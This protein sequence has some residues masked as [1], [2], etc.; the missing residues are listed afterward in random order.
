MSSSAAGRLVVVLPDPTK[1]KGLD[2]VSEQGNGQAA[3]VCTLR[4]AFENRWATDAHIL[5]ATVEP[6]DGSEPQFRWHKAALPSI[7][8][9]GYDL[10]L[11]RI[12]LEW[13]TP[14]HVEWTRDLW[15][16]YNEMI[17]TA[18]AGPLK[19][20]L[21]G[22]TAYY[23]TRRGVRWVFELSRDLPADEGESYIRGLAAFFTLHGIAVD[24]TP[25][26]LTW[27]QPFR[28]PHVVRD[29]KDKDG[30]V[31]SRSN[32]QDD[33]FFF[34]EHAYDRFLDPSLITPVAKVEAPAAVAVKED[35]PE[36]DAAVALVWGPSALTTLGVK[37]ERLLRG[38]DYYDFVFKF[39]APFGIEREKRHD[40]LMKWVASATTLLAREEGMTP[41][42]IY[43]IFIQIAKQF[44]AD[45]QKNGSRPFPLVELWRE[46]AWAWGREQGQIQ[47]EKAKVAAEEAAKVVEQQKTEARKVELSE[48]ITSG[49]RSWHPR[50]PASAVDAWMW[51]QKRFLVQTENRYYVMRPDGLY[52]ERDVSGTGIL[53]QVEHLNMGAVIQTRTETKQGTRPATL[54]E[55]TQRHVVV[56]AEDVIFKPEIEGGYLV[57]P[58][59]PNPM[60]V[61][62]SF[63]RRRDIKP[64]WNDN[65][66]RW[67]RSWA[68]VETRLGS[69]EYAWSQAHYDLFNRIIGCWLA[70]ERGAV[71]ALSLVA[72]NDAGK[73]LFGQ[74]FVE[75]FEK[76]G[77][78]TARDLSEG[79]NGSLGKYCLL[80]GNEG[81]QL[82]WGLHHPSDTFRMLVTG[83]TI[84]VNRKHRDIVMVSN[85]MRVL[86]T[87]NNL[88]LLMQLC[89]NRDLDPEDRRAIGVRLN[90]FAPGDAPCKVLR[91][92][93]GP[94]GTAGWIKGD[95]GQESKFIVAKHFLMLYEM[96]GKNALPNDAHHL[97]VAGN[98]DAP[99]IRQ[100]A[101]QGGSTPAVIET[102]VKMC[103]SQSFPKNGTKGLVAKDGRLYVVT[104]AIVDYWRENLSKG[105][106]EKLNL[107]RVTN[108]LKSISVSSTHT[109]IAGHNGRWRELDVQT[110]IEE[111]EQSGWTCNYLKSLLMQRSA[112]PST[113]NGAVQPVA[114]VIA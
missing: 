36:E 9:E 97:L 96:F 73:K 25:V 5:L 48:S 75:C 41:G 106:N 33:P 21:T 93:G 16:S 86:L 60:M 11:K 77:F 22:W 17:A 65:V 45:G 68:W 85:P 1:W 100:M 67:I 49:I 103:E 15:N 92:L 31:L 27:S 72:P 32:S 89:K 109:T 51:A 78:A 112:Q 12:L 29:K 69:G 19:P 63:R 57:N 50:L 80:W 104:G 35:Q 107:W 26:V 108:A 88:S 105:S 82:T 28:L 10:R 66:D 113:L 42:H 81:A 102:V 37:I 47:Q 18:E 58:D 59:S 71:A 111:A 114:G 7:R 53:A 40:T 30:N 14:G 101:T 55:L 87:A 43:G 44:D 79:F 91:E 3:T 90:H 62:P 52:N 4:E 64:E 46:V 99:I 24:M 70:V 6:F 61:V 110:L 76:A 23:A 20:F 95:S 94:E 56:A 98:P 39:V 84:A 8:A 2:H 83:D 34:F 74:G 54:A 38:R 13:D